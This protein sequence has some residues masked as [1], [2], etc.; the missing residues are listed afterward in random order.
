MYF[1]VFL[2][3]D[4]LFKAKLLR[5]VSIWQL[6]K[7]LEAKGQFSCE[8]SNLMAFNLTQVMFHLSSLSCGLFLQC[9]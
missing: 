9:R 7:L 1:T 2:F 4:G 8:I 6:I 5:I 3:S